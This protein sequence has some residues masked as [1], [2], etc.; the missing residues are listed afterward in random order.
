MDVGIEHLK[1][2]NDKMMSTLHLVFELESIT[3]GRINVENE[4]QR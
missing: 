1:T 4:V 2:K 3:P